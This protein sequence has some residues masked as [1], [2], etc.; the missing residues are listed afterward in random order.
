MIVSSAATSGSCRSTRRAL[1]GDRFGEGAGPF[2]QRNRDDGRRIGGDG[3]DALHEDEIDG[4]DI[5]LVGSRRD[6]RELESSLVVGDHGLSRV[7]QPHR[8][9]PDRRAF[10]CLDDGAGDGAGRRHLCRRG[11]GECDG[12]R[13]QEIAR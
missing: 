11:R 6:A 12:G 7:L 4:R 9:F 8:H 10:A 13:E 5:E 3:H 2:R 1:H